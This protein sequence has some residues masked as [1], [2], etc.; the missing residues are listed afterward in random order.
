MVSLSTVRQ[1]LEEFNDDNTK[2]GAEM[3]L[4]EEHE[5]VLLFPSTN[6]EKA[7]IK[8]AQDIENRLAKHT[9][10]QVVFSGI[11]E[12]KHQFLV[13]FTV[14]AKV[15]YKYL[16]DEATADVA[17]EAYGKDLQEMMTNAA[18]ATAALMCDL[19]D[20]EP[21]TKKTFSYEGKDAERVLFE[22]LEEL[23][24]IK[25]TENIL[26]KKFSI[27]AE[28]KKS[29]VVAIVEAWGDKLNPKKHKLGNDIKAVTL[30]KFSVKKTK[31]GYTCFVILDI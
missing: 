26:F 30:H 5:F 17:F 19:E 9:A 29:K 2:I 22:L 11:M 12:Q 3:D 16:P 8:Y 27:T 14:G 25:D 20:L 31:D 23:I 1:V 6:N 18:L 10:E 7:V 13:K 24:Y 21:K 28:E 4:F 15:P